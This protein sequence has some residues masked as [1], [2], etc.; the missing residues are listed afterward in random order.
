MESEK[1]RNS[2][3]FCTEDVDTSVS[4]IRVNGMRVRQGRAW[5]VEPPPPV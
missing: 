2:G 5:R 4:K 1:K 3:P